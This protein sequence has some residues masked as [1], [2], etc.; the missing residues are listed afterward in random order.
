VAGIEKVCELIGEYLGGDMYGYILHKKEA[1]KRL[2]LRE[3]L[4]FS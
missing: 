2:Y 4:E 3:L 1:Y